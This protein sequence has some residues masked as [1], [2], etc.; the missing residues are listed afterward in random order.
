MRLKRL[1]VKGSQFLYILTFFKHHVYP[2][3][4]KGRFNCNARIKFFKKVIFCS[5]DAAVTYKLSDSSLECNALFDESSITTV[6]ELYA[7]ITLI[8]CTKVKSIHC[9]TL[10]NVGTLLRK[11]KNFTTYHPKCFSNNKRHI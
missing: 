11:V 5:G 10:I 1:F 8:P 7:G 3:G 6:G 9:Q 4:A 2:Y